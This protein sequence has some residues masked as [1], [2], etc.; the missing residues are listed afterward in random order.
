[1]FFNSVFSFQSILNLENLKFL[2]DMTLSIISL[3]SETVE[4]Y[5][6]P[7]KRLRWNFLKAVNK[8]YKKYPP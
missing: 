2:S 7:A 8:I 1:M 4:G 6:E 5:L 3:I